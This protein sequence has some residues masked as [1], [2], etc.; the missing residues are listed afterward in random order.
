MQKRVLTDRTGAPAP[1]NHAVHASCA[2]LLWHHG[3][4]SEALA[5][6]EG[7]R[8]SPSSEI[9]K[10]WAL[11]QKMRSFLDEGE[12]QK[13][14]AQAHASEASPSTDAVHDLAAA[15]P[16]P[17]A[18]ASV[19][20]AAVDRTISRSGRTWDYWPCAASAPYFFLF[21]SFFSPLFF[22]FLS[23]YSFDKFLS[24]SFP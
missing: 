1:I 21:L 17:G 13:A 19:V 2:A 5:L 12:L 24:S 6:V 14:F 23:P 22:F 8:S 7:R 18:E 3:L 15:L 16:Y 10:V 9:V 4:A 20:Q 11:G